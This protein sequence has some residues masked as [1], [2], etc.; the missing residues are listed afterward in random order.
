MK[1]LSKF[2]FGLLSLLLLLYMIVPGATSISDFGALPDSSKSTLSGDTVQVPNLTAYYSNH[3]REFVTSYYF[4]SFSE[5]LRLPFSPIKLNYPPEFAYTAIKD[6]TQS[7]YLEEYL[8]P[9]RDSL[10]VNGMEPFLEDGTQ[11][12]WGA[13]KFDSE[14]E[15]YLTKTT[16]RYYPSGLGI[17]FVVW[18]GIVVSSYLIITLGRKVLLNA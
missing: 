18:F 4:N 11:R 7:T 10:F 16:I 8:Y 9:L 2:I 3:F 1:F 13:D 6:Q 17:R 14:G 15:E 12:F 5:T